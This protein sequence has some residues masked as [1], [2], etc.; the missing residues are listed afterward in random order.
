MAVWVWTM[1]G[2]SLR[3]RRKSSKKAAKFRNGDTDLERCGILWK[4]SD[5]PSK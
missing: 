5:G 2:R 3:M 1:A 4:R